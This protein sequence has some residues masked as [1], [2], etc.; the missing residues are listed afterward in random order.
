M[1]GGC[2]NTSCDIR[3]R[4][5]QLLV[6]FSSHIT[7]LIDFLLFT[8]PLIVAITVIVPKATKTQLKRRKES[9]K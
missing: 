3:N 4:L 5:S 2:K 1:K 7:V 8:L 9:P 6:H